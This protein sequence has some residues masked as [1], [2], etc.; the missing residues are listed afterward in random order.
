MNEDGI[1][2]AAITEFPFAGA[3]LPELIV[4]FTLDRPFMFAV[5]N[6]KGIPVFT[7]VLNAP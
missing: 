2:A 5:V 7:G 4:D 1:E 3:M 6:A